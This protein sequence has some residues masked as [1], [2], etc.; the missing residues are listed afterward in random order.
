MSDIFWINNTGTWDD[1]SH[2]SESS[3]GSTCGYVPTS[4][5]SVIFDEN[6]FTEDG[7]VVTII[8]YCK[9]QSMIWQ[10]IL[11]TPT[12]LFDTGTENQLT[13]QG[14][15]TFSSDMQIQSDAEVNL[16]NFI[17][18]TFKTEQTEPL[19]F[20]LIEGECNLISGQCG[21]LPSIKVSTT[22]KLILN[23]NLECETLYVIGDLD[24]QGYDIVTKGIKFGKPNMDE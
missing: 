8:N 10:N 20:I 11:H 23:D 14:N 16:Q 22:G 4:S 18:H 13:I 21:K 3:G 5:S 15:I 9:C 17:E 2:W 6:S 1:T 24:T 19:P 7:H 12:L